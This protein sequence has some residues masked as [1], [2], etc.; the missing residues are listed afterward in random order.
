MNPLTEEEKLARTKRRMIYLKVGG[1]VAAIVIIFFMYQGCQKSKNTQLAYDQ[2]RD[3]LQKI[4]NDTARMQGEARRLKYENA[5][6]DLH[7][8]D[9]VADLQMTKGAL[10]DE[11]DK[12]QR[13]SNEVKAA[14]AKRDT[15][16]YFEKCDSLADENIFLRDALLHNDSVVKK[17]LSLTDQRI[18]KSDS[19]ANSWK[20]A[21]DECIRITEFVASELPKVKP[22]SKLYIDGAAMTGYVNAIGGGLSLVDTKGNKFAVKYMLTNVKPIYQVE[23]GRLLSFKR[24]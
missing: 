18:K 2:I 5:D 12:R 15:I 22:K 19:L 4:I 16:S 14:K 3:S 6:L 13:L 11:G 9:L 7:I 23:Y 10:I 17:I 20:L 8:A 24:K 21:Y 1:G